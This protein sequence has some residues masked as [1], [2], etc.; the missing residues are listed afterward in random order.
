[1][2]RG[3]RLGEY[4]VT[5]D[6][7]VKILK[8]TLKEP[9]WLDLSFGARALY[10]LLKS[11]HSGK[12]NGD[13]YLGVRK[14]AK[15]LGSGRA[16]VERWFHEL[17]EHGFIR[18]TAAAFLGLDGKGTATR[19]R[20]TELG[21]KGDQPTRE[22][23]DWKPTPKNKTPPS[24]RGRTVPKMMTPCHQN[25]DTC[26]QNEDGFDPKQGADR[27]QN[28]G[29][30]LH[31]TGCELAP[32]PYSS[33]QHPPSDRAGRRSAPPSSAVASL[34]A[35]NGHRPFE[36]SNRSAAGFLSDVAR[37]L[38]R[39]E[40]IEGIELQGLRESVTAIRES[41]PAG[42]VNQRWAATILQS[43]DAQEAIA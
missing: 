1:M 36:N 17:D 29:R 26:H 25:D 32:L 22:F 2:R 6:P 16:S 20:L 28:D 40:R 4:D 18:K 15:E 38:K 34:P 35:G 7:F 21:W 14:A 43:F 42:S 31:H 19:W 3:S 41:A 8:P 33:P 30:V 12:N 10:V 9:A 37:R 27:H 5:V 13:I 24:K 39:R 11:Y 23:K